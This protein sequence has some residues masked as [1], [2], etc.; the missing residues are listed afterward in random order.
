MPDRTTIIGAVVHEDPG[1]DADLVDPRA[2][3]T[4]T[5]A[6]STR[7]RSASSKTVTGRHC[8]CRTAV[9]Q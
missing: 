1:I 4:L 6:S 8:R 9:A 5:N 7:R 3:Y 2:A